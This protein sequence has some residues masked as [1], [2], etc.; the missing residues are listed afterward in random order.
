MSFIRVN[1]AVAH[2]RDEGPTSGLPLVFINALGS[3]F[4]IWDEV[5]TILSPEFRVLR[6]DM[7]GHGLSKSCPDHYDVADF[8]RD[9]GALMDALA[10]SRATVV[11]LSMGGLIAQ[12]LYRQRPELFAALALAGTAAKIGTQ[13]SWDARMATIEAGGIE[14]IAELGS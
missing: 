13:E 8:A 14:L 1:G 7:R 3:D 12:E 4:R 9:L 5:A 10:I 2:F 6:Y 11:G